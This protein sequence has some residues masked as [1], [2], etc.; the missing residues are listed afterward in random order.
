VAFDILSQPNLAGKARDNSKCWAAPELFIKDAAATPACDA[1]L[2]G[3]L[4]A[5]GVTTACFSIANY[6]I[7]ILPPPLL[8]SVLQ[9]SASISTAFPRPLSLQQLLEHLQAILRALC[10]GLARRASSPAAD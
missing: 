7:Y 5:A 1:W 6:H 8:L 9:L 3:M 2:A 4:F 10:L